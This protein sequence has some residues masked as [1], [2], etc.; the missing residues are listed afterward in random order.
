[1]IDL[2]NDF[3]AIGLD[4]SIGKT[5][6]AERNGRTHQRCICAGSIAKTGNPGKN[7]ATSGASRKDT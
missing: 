6:T 1:L 4:G 7:A 3:A 5:S 2:I